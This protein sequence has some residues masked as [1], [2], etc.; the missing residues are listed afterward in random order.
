MSKLNSELLASSVEKVLQYSQ[1][2]SI[3]LKGETIKGKTRKF[4]ESVELQVTL[5]NY[6]PARDK[7]FSGSFRLPVIPKAKSTVCVLGNQK[8]CEKA[9]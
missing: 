9:D 4:T 5:K 8:H 3:E 7:R 1:G 2:E 6:D